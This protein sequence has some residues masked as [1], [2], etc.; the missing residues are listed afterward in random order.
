MPDAAEMKRKRLT[1]HEAPTIYP[2]VRA[3]DVDDC[4]VYWCGISGFPV[5]KFDRTWLLSFLQRLS[6]YLETYRQ[7]RQEV[8]LQH[9]ALLPDLMD[10]FQRRSMQYVPLA[11]MTLVPGAAPVRPPDVDDLRK[12]AKEA[13]DSGKSL[14]VLRWMPDNAHW[15]I[16]KG[17]EAQR[18]DFFGH[19]GLFS[20]F[21]PPD[22]KAP[23]TLPELPRFITTHPAWTGQLHDGLAMGASLQDDFLARSKEVFGGPIEDDPSFP[24]LPFVLPL[25]TAA[26]VVAVSPDER[27]RWFTVFDGYWIESKP[28]KGLLLVIK[29]ADFDE[30]LIDI[31]EGMRAEGLTYRGRAL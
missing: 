4:S 11:G 29:D 12:A 23:S 3:R 13:N 2:F 6:R 8:F 31:L 15:F 14:D 22:P 19:G 17:A 5:N 20:L 7:L 27:Q 1:D 21:L 30:I 10:T 9:K 25:L 18:A 16:R 28:D 26:S 24:G